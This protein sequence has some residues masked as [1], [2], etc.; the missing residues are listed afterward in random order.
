MSNRVT[1]AREIEKTAVDGLLAEKK[2]ATMAKRHGGRFSLSDLISA[3]RA[4]RNAGGE[5]K[6]AID[7]TAKE[8]AQTA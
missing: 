7:R 2:K 5:L 8:S 3:N 1:I 4:A 6:S